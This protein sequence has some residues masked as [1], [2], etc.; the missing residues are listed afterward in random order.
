VRELGGVQAHPGAGTA[1]GW[2]KQRNGK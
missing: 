2:E 1:R